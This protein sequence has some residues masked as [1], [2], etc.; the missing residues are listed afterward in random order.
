MKNLQR[1]KAWYQ[2]V[3]SYANKAAFAEY[4]S[5]GVWFA[6][7]IAPRRVIRGVHFVKDLTA[8]V[9]PILNPAVINI[10]YWILD[11]EF[12]KLNFTALQKCS[13]R[14]MSQI[15]VGLFS[16]F[17]IH[18]AHHIRHT[19]GVQAFV[20]DVGRHDLP[21]PIVKDV[22]NIVED[23]YIDDLARQDRYDL[24]IDFMRNILNR[25]DLVT[26][27][28]EA[29]E[30]VPPEELY[31]LLMSLMAG[32]INPD[33]RQHPIFQSGVPGEL[34]AVLS[35]IGEDRVSAVRQVLVILE[36]FLKENGQELKDQ[37]GTSD[38]AGYDGRSD[39]KF[40]NG[41]EAQ[42]TTSEIAEAL[43]EAI[44][45]A[46]TDREFKF[47]ESAVRSVPK[48]VYREVPQEETIDHLTVDRRFLVVGRILKLLRSKNITPGIP[49]KWG[50]RILATRLTRLAMDNKVFGGPV[51]RRV[52]TDVECV[53]LCDLSGSMQR[54]KRYIK[55]L[56]AA[57]GA[58]TSLA[59]N[60][61]PI[62]V[63]GHTSL[64]EQG[65]DTPVIYKIASNGLGFR[66]SNVRYQFQQAV[67]IETNNNFDG[68]AIEEAAT[69]FTK[70][71]KA[72]KILIVLSD[73][74]PHGYG[75][76]TEHGVEHTKG[77]LRNLRKQ[78]IH[79]VALS[80]VAD[81]MDNNNKIYGEDFN[82]PAYRNLEQVLADLILKIG[83][84]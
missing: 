72:D 81:V 14:E 41:E 76:P 80:L 43:A 70:H 57:W 49:R 67:G 32:Y 83:Y 10:P 27:D 29:F 68:F 42:G 1:I 66:T 47:V 73:G 26:R 71:S 7:Q 54:D 40:A 56:A 53:L 84:S 75:Y 6:T 60:R 39:G 74:L 77:V 65:K 35:N 34:A 25:Y 2:D 15:L 55:A 9:D 5:H 37:Q 31:P 69:F 22:I 28:A 21:K 38:L 13:R 46:D 64:Q 62:A 79:I 23:I 45:K 59:E 63:L 24:F 3:P 20:R 36:R 16:A 19:P 50:S 8:S 58:Y 11:P 48:V 4:I 51:E 61:I 44:L 52:K 17:V 18:E 33:N 30:T 12:I 78:G 82:F